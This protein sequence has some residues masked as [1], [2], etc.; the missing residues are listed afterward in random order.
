MTLQVFSMKNKPARHA[1]RI[2]MKEGMVPGVIG[3]LLL[4]AMITALAF[5]QFNNEYVR[6]KVIFYLGTV[7]FLE[8]TFIF[9]VLLAFVQALFSFQLLYQ[10]GA[11]NFY[12]GTGLNRNQLFAT[13][14]AAGMTWLSI[15]VCLAMASGAA[16]NLTQSVFATTHTRLILGNT[17]IIGFGLLLSALI[18]YTVTAL[19]C[20]LAGTLVET[21]VYGLLALL[22][23]TFISLG[24]NGQM[25]AFLWGNAHDV[26]DIWEYDLPGNLVTSLAGFNPL[27][28]FDAN[29]AAYGYR[30]SGYTSP[31]EPA[32]G[33]VLGWIFFT[34]VLLWLARKFFIG[35]K[36]EKTGLRGTCK[37]LGFILILPLIYAAGSIP[38]YIASGHSPI[39]LP[40]ALAIGIGLSAAAFFGLAIPLRL[41]DRPV[42]KGLLAYPAYLAIIGATIALLLVGG[43]GYVGYQP[44]AADVTRVS[45]S[46]KG[47]PN[48]V[49]RNS[50]GDAG[51]F[52]NS[53]YN[54]HITLED[55]EDIKTALTLHRRLIDQGGAQPGK[56]ITNYTLVEYTLKN[57]K[58]TSRFYPKATSDVLES[59][60][61]LDQT[62]AFRELFKGVMNGMDPKSD[63]SGQ[64]YLDIY[65][66]FS[67]GT[68]YLATPLSDQIVL[69]D[70]TLSEKIRQSLWEDVETQSL[71]ERYKPTEPES[72]ILYFIADNMHQEDAGESPSP[73]T[74]GIDDFDSKFL[75]RIYIDQSYSKTLSLLSGT[76]EKPDTKEIESIQIIGP[77]W[78]ILMGTNY[79]DLASCFSATLINAESVD[80]RIRQAKLNPGMTISDTGR[81][82]ELFRASR[83]FYFAGDKGYLILVQFRGGKICTTRYIPQA[84][85][86][87]WAK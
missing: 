79:R 48:L 11:A 56:S 60:L 46:Y 36:V 68:L 41:I 84:V 67:H 85:M 6:E 44:D 12:F 24:L 72:Y 10:R 66:P 50:Y 81:I 63:N 49:L 64:S 61:S 34:A 40:T 16:V 9:I 23:P 13:R 33:P 53:N 31:D 71:E 78:D 87:E 15:A 54:M 30:I 3:A 39:P 83:G 26:Q 8:P 52:I 76:T 22:L 35:R 45:I 27:F 2:A 59:M 58:K 80:S 19:V 5:A 25:T 42:W 86:P 43:L 29:L 82:D 28:F 70:E 4:T 57:G 75:S 51:G 65:S 1:F 14:F 38:L 74:I 20:A 32:W 77:Y 21:L 62:K 55:P 7:G 17:L 47:I 73:Q 18:A 69:I 37:P